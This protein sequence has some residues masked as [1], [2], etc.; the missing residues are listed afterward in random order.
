MDLEQAITQSHLI[1]VDVME[2]HN[3]FWSAW[4]LENGNLVV[5]YGR[6]GH[7]AQ[8]K[9]HAIGNVNDATLV[10]DKRVESL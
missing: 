1:C 5:E 8:S 10:Q 6:V 9:L 4:V 7:T 2:N 3:K